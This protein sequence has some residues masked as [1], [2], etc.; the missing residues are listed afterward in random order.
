M[1]ELESDAQRAAE[2]LDDCLT[3][4]STASCERLC[5][6]MTHK[7]EDFELSGYQKYCFIMKGLL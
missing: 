5:E 2:Q 6:F 3:I 1:A 4:N 7:K